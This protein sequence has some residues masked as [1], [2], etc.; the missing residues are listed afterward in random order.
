M[1]HLIDSH[2]VTL[3]SVFVETAGKTLEELSEIFE[4]DNPRKA[5]IVKVRV[6]MD[7]HGNLVHVAYLSS[8]LPCR[9]AWVVHKAC[10]MVGPSANWVGEQSLDKAESDVVAAKGM[11]AGGEYSLPDS[12]VALDYYD[13]RDSDIDTDLGLFIALR[14]DELNTESS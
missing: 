6:G 8:P 11:I 2:T 12:S 14:R 13:N 5:S 9:V 10:T 4:A 3:C 1:R 7:V